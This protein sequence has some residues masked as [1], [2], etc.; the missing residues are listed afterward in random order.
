MARLK[1][2][3]VQF[4]VGAWQGDADVQGWTDDLLGGYFRLCLYLYSNNGKLDEQQIPNLLRPCC[5]KPDEVW[6]KVAHK[7]SKTGTTISQK[8][9]TQELRSAKRLMQAKRR[10]GLARAKQVQD[11]SRTPDRTPSA[12]ESKG[13]VSKERSKRKKFVPPTIEQVCAYRQQNPELHN[14]DADDFYKGYADAGWI[15]TQGKPVR[16]WKLKMR[17][18]S[19]YANKE[20]TGAQSVPY[21]RIDGKTPRERM[22]EIE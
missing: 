2:K 6:K 22:E 7:F 15:D 11:T 3:Y 17:T 19:K 5:K 10:G 8:R 20:A 21:E 12:K 9:V 1:P 18:R 13:K 4:E 16:N 14:I